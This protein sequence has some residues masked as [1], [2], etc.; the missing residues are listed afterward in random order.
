MEQLRDLRNAIIGN[1][2]EKLERYKKGEVDNIYA[3]TQ[4]S[5]QDRQK[6]YMCMS[7]LLAF[8]NGKPIPRPA[9]TH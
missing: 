7:V 4:S 2:D 6:L 3:L 1:D 8:I 9:R 5:I